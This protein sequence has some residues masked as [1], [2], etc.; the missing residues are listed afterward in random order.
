LLCEEFRERQKRINPSSRAGASSSSCCK[1]LEVDFADQ[2]ATMSYYP[3]RKQGPDAFDQGYP[4]HVDN[5]PGTPSPP[6][7]QYAAQASNQGYQQQQQQQPTSGSSGAMVVVAPEYC[8]PSA[9]SLAVTKKVLSFSGGDWTISDP[10]GNIVFRVDGK[11]WTVRNRMYLVD[12]AG[13]KVISMQRKVSSNNI[14]LLQQRG[15]KWCPK[16]PKPYIM[17]LSLSLSLS[18][19]I[20]CALLLVDRTLNFL[21]KIWSVTDEHSLECL[22]SKHYMMLEEIHVCGSQFFLV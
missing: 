17:N 8:L 3:L 19:L 12:A 13:Y 9:I 20:P 14:F 10:A 18:H 16:N 15:L 1:A 5:P 21:R 11:V 6:P 7:S 4:P 2:T 22:L